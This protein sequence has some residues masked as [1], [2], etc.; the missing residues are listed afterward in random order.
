MKYLRASRSVH[1]FSMASIEIT[2]NSQIISCSALPILRTQMKPIESPQDY[3]NRIMR[4]SDLNAARVA[5]RAQKLGYKLSSGYVHNI[6][7]GAADNPSIQL[8]QALAAGLGRPEDEVDLVFRGRPITD[9]MSY[10]NSLFARM[11]NEYKELDTADQRE[12]RGIIEMLQRE[13]QRRLGS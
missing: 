4:D 5:E 9:D 8:M 11:W 7:T 1:P 12:L 2:E 13:I 6:A 3:V 10:R